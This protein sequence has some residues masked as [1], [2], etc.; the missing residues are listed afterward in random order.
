M[1]DRIKDLQQQ[2]N[3]F[4]KQTDIYYGQNQRNLGRIRKLEKKLKELESHDKGSISGRPLHKGSI[5]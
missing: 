5:E 1:S 4:R 2:L 3:Y